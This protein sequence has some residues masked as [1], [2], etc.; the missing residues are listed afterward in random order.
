MAPLDQTFL[1]GLGNSQRELPPD[2]TG[3]A[4]LKRLKRF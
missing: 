2:R 4:K 1:E 3:A